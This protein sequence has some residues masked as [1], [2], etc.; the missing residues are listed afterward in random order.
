MYHVNCGPYTFYFLCVYVC[1]CE[2]L[3][4]IKKNERIYRISGVHCFI[5]NQKNDDDD[6]DFYVFS[7]LTNL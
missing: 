2:I 5:I 7:V 1:V 3:I 6:D 4:I